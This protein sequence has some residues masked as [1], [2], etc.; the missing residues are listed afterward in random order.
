MAT[1]SSMVTDVLVPPAS[2]TNSTPAVANPFQANWGSSG[3]KFMLAAAVFTENATLYDY[4]KLLM[5]SSSCASFTGSVIAS[6]Q[7]SESGRDQQHTQLGLGNWF[8]AFTTI[9][10]QYDPTHWFALHSNR[11]AAGFEYTAQYLMNGTVSYDPSFYR[12]DANLLG[13]PWSQI[14]SSG[15][16]PIRPVFE[17]PYAHYVGVMGVEMPYTKALIE[18]VGIDGQNPSTAISDNAAWD[19]LRFRT[20]AY[21]L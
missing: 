11:L 15:L 21:K 10:N 14:S 17:G 16:W 6:G 4:A 3:E 8:E 13:G 20:Q 7:S 1:F 5:N 12:C 19:T 18:S 2:L 9:K